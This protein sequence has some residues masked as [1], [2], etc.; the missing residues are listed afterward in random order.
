M[1]VCPP[2]VLRRAEGEG[3]SLR[4]QQH[5]EDYYL[6]EEQ[7]EDGGLF[8]VAIRPYVSHLLR[9]AEDVELL[10]AMDPP[11]AAETSVL[12]DTVNYF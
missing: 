1:Q 2:P 7:G 12:A 9:N 11:P 8:K 10:F 3:K 6:G 5:V 4:L